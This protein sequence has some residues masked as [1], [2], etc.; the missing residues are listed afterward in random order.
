MA[1]QGMERREVLRV[2]ALAAAASR[3]PG[4]QRWAFAC[5]HLAG[6]APQSKPAQYTPQFFNPHEYAT[7][8]RLTEIILPSDGSPGAHEAGVSEFIDFMVWSDSS[9]QY[10]FRYGLAWLDA[11]ASNMHGKPFLDLGADPQTSILDHL[12]YKDR[13]RS[14]EE[15]GRAFFSLARECTL[16]GFYTSKA[17]LEALDFPGLKFYTESPG[18]PHGDDPEHLHLQ[19]PKY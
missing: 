13:Y 15:D 11:H 2:M 14:G 4:F 19:S 6:D 9:L 8:E 16:M 17:G 3:Y 12:A 5:D 1:G 10:Q 18:C 7:L